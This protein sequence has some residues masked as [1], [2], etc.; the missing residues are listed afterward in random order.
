MN[1]RSRS[2]CVQRCVTNE[3]PVVFG[4]LTLRW[5]PVCHEVM[6][7]ELPTPDKVPLRVGTHSGSACLD[8]TAAR[9]KN[10]GHPAMTDVKI[11]GSLVKLEIGWGKWVNQK[12]RRSHC[13]SSAS[14]CVP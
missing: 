6:S 7:V 5:T 13:R 12:S 2:P 4:E 10:A 1:C 14:T 3:R 11:R 9:E 8:R